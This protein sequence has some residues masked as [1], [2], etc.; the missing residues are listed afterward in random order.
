MRLFVY[1]RNCERMG[2]SAES[3]E[4]TCAEAI[5]REVN[6]ALDEALGYRQRILDLAGERD[7]GAQKE[8]ELLLKES[9]YALDKAR[10]IGDLV[11]GAFFAHE[12]DKDREKERQL[13]LDGVRAWL[14]SDG[15]IPPELRGLSDDIRER[16]PVFHW[17]LEFPEVDRKSV[18]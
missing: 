18:V 11:I 17:P 14:R 5:E 10:A 3:I 1:Q 4:D 7:P 13:R 15:E 8:K 6:A 12:K 9:E 2:S 16:I